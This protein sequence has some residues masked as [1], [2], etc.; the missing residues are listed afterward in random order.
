MVIPL[1]VSR[2]ARW[3]QG[4]YAFCTEWLQCCVLR[5]S[6]D[7]SVFL[8]SPCPLSLPRSLFHTPH[9]L[10]HSLCL[11]LEARGLPGLQQRVPPKP[12]D[13]PSLLCWL[14]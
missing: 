13:L 10:T 1:D 4:L 6:G 12:L 14:L 9:A 7:Y 3:A 8:S 5:M 2:A 11:N